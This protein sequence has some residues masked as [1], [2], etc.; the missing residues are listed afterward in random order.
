MKPLP[1]PHFH[2]QPPVLAHF[3]YFERNERRL[4]SSPCCLSVYPPL[5][6]VRKIMRPPSSLC[7]LPIFAMHVPLP[8]TI[9]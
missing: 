5:I 7:A 2:T 8:V 4:M 9:I 3:P 1:P 6:F